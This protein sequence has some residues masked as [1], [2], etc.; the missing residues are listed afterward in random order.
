MLK[1]YTLIILIC[2]F[3][4]THAQQNM[5]I[6]HTPATANFARFATDK[7]F[8]RNHPEPL[9]YV[10]Q[11]ETGRIVTFETPDGKTAEAFFLK[12]PVDS[13]DYLF[14][15]HEWWGLNDHI[16]KE[17][18]KYYDDL[19]VV[20]VLALDLY[21]GK[22]A[23]SQEQASA[24]MKQVKE[25]RA[26]AIIKGAIDFVGI[27]AEI[28]TIGWCFGGGWAL[29]AAIQAGDEAQGAVMYY[30]MPEN[31]PVKIKKI[32][33][34]VLGIFASKDEW[35]TPEIV[36]EFQAKMEKASGDLKIRF[37]EAEHAFANPSNP[38]YDKEATEDAYRRSLAFLKKV[39]D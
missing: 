32:D 8:N 39:L 10:H 11:S 6:C 12:A 7:T 2:F 37:Y 15:I 33:F 24:F 4:V 16:K 20:N 23:T 31:D 5:T 30:G 26:L 18:E 21:D 28:A 27:S 25:E 14:V 3:G 36:N 19:E 29:Q 22:V 13:D 17:A 38:Q 35:I 9:P 1:L 34:P